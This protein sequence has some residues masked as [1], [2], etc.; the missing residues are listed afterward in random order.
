MVPNP[1]PLRFL[2][3][4]EEVDRHRSLSCGGY[5]TCLDRVLRRSWRSWTCER[6]KLFPLTRNWHAAEIAHEAVLQP[7]E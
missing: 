1:T 5:D 3:K 2:V 4:H 6:C 7:A